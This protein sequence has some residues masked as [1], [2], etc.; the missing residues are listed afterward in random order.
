MILRKKFVAPALPVPTSVYD[1]NQQDN[2]IRALRLYFNL[3]DEL[4][5][6]LKRGD[7]AAAIT[8][9]NS[10]ISPMTN[11]MQEKMDKLASIFASD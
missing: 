2:L 10:R 6:L 7:N 3:L 1:R 9:I 4:E 5:P 11:G 8:L